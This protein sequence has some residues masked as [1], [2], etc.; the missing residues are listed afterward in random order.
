MIWLHPNMIS[1]RNEFE[2]F[3]F[4]LFFLSGNNPLR[5][6]NSASKCL[7]ITIKVYK[8]QPE[9]NYQKKPS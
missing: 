2:G 8:I 4:I 6:L 5:M 1:T 7:K 9:N 3:I